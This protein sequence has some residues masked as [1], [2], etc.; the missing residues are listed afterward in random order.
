LTRADVGHLEKVAVQT[1]PFAGVAKGKFVHVRGAGRHYHPRQPVFLDVF[2][3][4]L[5]PRVGAHKFVGRGNHHI[6]MGFHGFR[7]FLHPHG[8]GDVHPAMANV[9]ADF[10]LLMVIH[11]LLPKVLASLRVL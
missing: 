4:H 7:H 2:L 11:C 6:G 8:L 10:F 1:R 5:L 3:Y 9:H